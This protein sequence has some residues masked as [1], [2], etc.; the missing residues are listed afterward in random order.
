M[1]GGLPGEC[2]GVPALEAG[3]IGKELV[4]NDKG[5]RNGTSTLPGISA[6]LH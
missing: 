5:A 6:R 1:G 2:R 4:D 3:W